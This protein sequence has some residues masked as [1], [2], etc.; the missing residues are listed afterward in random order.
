M[1]LYYR[2]D[3]LGTKCH[4][5]DCNHDHSVLVLHAKCHPRAGTWVFYDKAS[6]IATI[7]C[8]KCDNEILSLAIASRELP[9]S[10]GFN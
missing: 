8:A 9:G 5:P 3:L 4:L 6:G 7:R 1:A 2:E 10:I